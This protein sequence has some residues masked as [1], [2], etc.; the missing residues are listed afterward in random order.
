MLALR[1]CVYLHIQI[2]N[3]TRKHMVVSIRDRTMR[4][5]Y[6]LDYWNN[7]SEKRLQ[8]ETWDSFYKIYFLLLCARMFCRYRYLFATFMQCPQRPEKALDSVTT[9]VMCSG[10]S[11]RAYAGTMHRFCGRPTSDL[12]LWDFSP[13]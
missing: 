4:L 5:E 2:T 13:A 11:P 3:I 8:L 7:K 1:K 12:H 9:A 10:V 6:R